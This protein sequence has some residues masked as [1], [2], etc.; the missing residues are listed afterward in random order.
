MVRYLLMNS[1]IRVVDNTPEQSRLSEICIATKNDKTALN[2]STQKMVSH[3]LTLVIK[4]T[5]LT[6]IGFYLNLIT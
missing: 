4:M 2:Q 3:L 1:Q 5:S 6:L